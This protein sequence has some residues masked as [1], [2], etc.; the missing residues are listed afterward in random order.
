MTVSQPM[1]PSNGA[2]AGSATSE[3]ATTTRA[4]SART[5]RADS[6]QCA[7]PGRERH[8]RG[9]TPPAPGNS[10]LGIRAGWLH[11]ARVTHRQA[12]I[13]DLDGFLTFPAAIFTGSLRR[14]GPNGS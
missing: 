10:R 7:E 14:P 8:R 12:G 9:E 4:T 1:T 5:Q 6:E 13:R 3:P 11:D 2:T